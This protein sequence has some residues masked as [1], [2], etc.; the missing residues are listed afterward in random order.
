M[1]KY[2]DV[3]YARSMVSVKVGRTTITYV[4]SRKGWGF[5]PTDLSNVYALIDQDSDTKVDKVLVLVRDLRTPSG[6]ALR[7]N[8]LFISGYDDDAGEVKRGAIW[9]I[10]DVHSKALA[11]MVREFALLCQPD[12]VWL[13][14]ILHAA[15]AESA[16]L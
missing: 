6:I 15:P 16:G 3:P 13:H 4:G 8:S 1:V 7:G 14:S 10:E 11:G 2:A 12:C 5:A 9:K